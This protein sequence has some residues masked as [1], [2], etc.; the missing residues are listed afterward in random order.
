MSKILPLVMLFTRLQYYG[1]IINHFQ[2]CL[3][4]RT[5]SPSN[6]QNCQNSQLSVLIEVCVR[7]YCIN[8]I[9]RRIILSDT[10]S[11]YYLLITKIT[12]KHDFSQIFGVIRA[13]NTKSFH[14]YCSVLKSSTQVK[15]SA[16]PREGSCI[17]SCLFLCNWQ[18]MT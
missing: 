10:F 11:Y 17:N 9:H 13:H 4:K 16:V 6:S 2:R 7:A 15:C 18:I 5:I 1:M 14:D 8:L 3:F 12:K